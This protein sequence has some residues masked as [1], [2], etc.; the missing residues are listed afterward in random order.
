MY[1]PLAAVFLGGLL[2]LLSGCLNLNEIDYPPEVIPDIPP[3]DR[4]E[5]TD[6]SPPIA[7]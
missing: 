4:S 5:D 2:V 7:K 6:W 1:R 3:G